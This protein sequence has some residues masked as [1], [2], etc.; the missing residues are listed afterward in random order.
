MCRFMAGSKILGDE[1]LAT[2]A[3]AREAAEARRH[4][5]AVFASSSSS[6]DDAAPT[7]PTAEAPEGG[8]GEEQ[9]EKSLGD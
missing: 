3:G 6:A 1:S 5:D 8:D 4:A 9:A 7:S 2:S